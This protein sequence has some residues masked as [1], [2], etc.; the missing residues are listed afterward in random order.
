QDQRLREEKVE[1]GRNFANKLWNVARFVIMQL[2]DSTKLEQPALSDRDSLP[3]EDRWILSKLDRL[4]SDVDRLVRDFQLNEA[5]HHMYD[6]LW[7]DYCDWYVEMAKVRLRDPRPQTPDPRPVLVHVLETGL[8]L[9][10]PYM[11]YV[12]EELWQRLRTY[13]AQPPAE[14]LIAAP[15]PQHDEAWRDAEAERQLDGVIDVVRAI[16]NI[17]SEKLIEPARHIEAYV[18]TNDGRPAVEAGAAYIE[19]LARVQPLHIVSQASDA[20]R[21]GVAT[22][23][24]PHAQVVVPLADLLDTGAERDRLSK[25]IEEAEAYLRRLEGKLSNEQF[26]SKAPREVV[27]AEEERRDAT[28]TRLE[29]LRGAL[30]ELG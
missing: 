12:T 25:E 19:A 15:Y 27:A 10:H 23:V 26:R 2:D 4:T 24:L 18:V 7:G 30:A 17:R 22:A 1:G 9:L 6:F 8:R 14:M 11:P 5:G 29:G 3:A 20:P 16:R 28:Q 21:E 13:M